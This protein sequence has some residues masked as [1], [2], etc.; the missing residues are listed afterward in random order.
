M[1]DSRLRSLMKALSWRLLG[2]LITGIIVFSITKEAT[3]AFGAGIIDSLIKIIVYYFHER[4]WTKVPIGQK[5]SATKIIKD[6][7]SDTPITNSAKSTVGY[8][9]S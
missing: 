3:T 5:N 6:I 4:I 9:Q 2:S 7:A 1:Q 8:A